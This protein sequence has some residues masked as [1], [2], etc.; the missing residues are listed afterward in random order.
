MYSTRSPHGLIMLRTGGTFPH[1][2]DLLAATHDAT[3]DFHQAGLVG[4]V[5][6]NWDSRGIIYSNWHL[7]VRDSACGACTYR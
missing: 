3:S 5:V 6:N 7:T 4:L 1:G 2:G